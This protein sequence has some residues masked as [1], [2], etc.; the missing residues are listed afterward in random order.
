MKKNKMTIVLYLIIMLIVLIMSVGLTI[1]YFNKVNKNNNNV[2][3][4]YINLLTTYENGNKINLNSI[5]KGLEKKYAFS[6]SNSSK[7]SVGNYKVTLKVITPLSNTIDNNF[8]Y[9]LESSTQSEDKNNI[10]VEKE[11]TP[12]PMST[13]DIGSATITPDTTHD[14]V[15]T[16]RYNNVKDKVDLNGR[17]FVCEIDIVSE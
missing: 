15:L 16:I 3:V 9:V 5:N 1:L 6:V 10:L 14:Y 8:V 17:I 13:K 2:L 12:V 4:K 11:E 7:D